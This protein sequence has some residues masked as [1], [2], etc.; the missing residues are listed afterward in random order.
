MA[1]SE[2]YRQVR[3][4]T[5]EL[6]VPLEVEDFVLQSMADA[7]PVRWHLAHT[8]WFFETF[9]L[10]PHVPGH[11]SPHEAYQHL[12]NSYYQGVGSPFER[13]RRGLLSRP[14]VA[15]VRSYRGLVDRSVGELLEAA[16]PEQ[17]AALEPIVTLG[18]HHEQ[19]QLRR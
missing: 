5:E 1:L 7:S 17:F 2:R 19:Q 6:C 13:S 10:R 14:T 8:T 15:E 4:A 18:L 3:A 12:F 11:R 9:V 16:S